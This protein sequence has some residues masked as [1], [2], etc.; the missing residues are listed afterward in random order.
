M[1]AD[2]ISY[3]SMLVARDSANWAFWGM[4]AAWGSAFMSLITCGLACFALNTWKK[5][6][7]LK[8]KKDF[9][10]SLIQ[11]RRL[12]IWLPGT[13]DV[14]TLM[15]GRRLIYDSKVT[16]QI[17]MDAGRFN[18]CKDYA[19]N[20]Q[21]LEDGMQKCWECWAATED[22]LSKT[23]IGELWRDTTSMYNEYTQGRSDK[24]LFID[25]IDGIYKKKFVF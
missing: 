20:F 10:A 7:Q 14:A 17:G 21:S 12:L 9:K 13:I 1:D 6:E 5:Q 25:K 16:M 15:A 8:V 11:L 24:S 3:E 2:L 18:H 4:I 22:L 23:E 19:M